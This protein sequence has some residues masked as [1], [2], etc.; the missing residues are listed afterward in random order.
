M[1]ANETSQFDEDKLEAEQL[2]E[3]E[4]VGNPAQVQ[5]EVRQQISRYG[6]SLAPPERRDRQP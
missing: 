3:S 6:P 4:D 2:F 5:Q 1:R